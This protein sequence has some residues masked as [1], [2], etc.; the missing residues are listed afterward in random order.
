MANKLK[1]GWAVMCPPNGVWCYFAD[2]WS[3]CGKWWFTGRLYPSA[4]VTAPICKA[5]AQAMEK[6][7]DV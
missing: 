4:S 6:A 7:M 3:A 2:Q 1:T 5:C